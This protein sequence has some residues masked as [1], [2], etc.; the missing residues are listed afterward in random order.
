MTK[1]KKKQF[2]ILED[3]MFHR[4]DKC[5]SVKNGEPITCIVC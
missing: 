4:I 5:Q 3:A 2:Y 1:S